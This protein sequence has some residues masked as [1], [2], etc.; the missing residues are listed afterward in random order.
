MVMVLVVFGMILMMGWVI[1]IVIV[2]LFVL[3]DGGVV[4]VVVF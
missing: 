4:D 2:E 3:N 1:F